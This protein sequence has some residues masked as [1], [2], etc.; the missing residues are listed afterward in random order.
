MSD[1]DVEAPIPRHRAPLAAWAHAKSTSP[2]F[3]PSFE[4][5]G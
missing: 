3:T 1:A 4:G 2:G 5:L